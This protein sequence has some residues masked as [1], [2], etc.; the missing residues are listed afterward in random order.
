MTKNCCCFDL[1]K[2]ITKQQHVYQGI[3]QAYLDMWFCFRLEFDQ[4][5]PN[6]CWKS[7]QKWH[8]NS[9]TFI[10]IHFISIYNYSSNNLKIMPTPY[11]CRQFDG[12]LFA[13]SLACIVY[14]SDQNCYTGVSVSELFGNPDPLL[15]DSLSKQIL[16]ELVWLPRTEAINI[17]GLLV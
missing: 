3:V 15:S 16:S 4:E 8:E 6:K 5:L 12:I 13:S 7:G 2:K 14:E 9:A 1:K 11:F 10:K 17:S